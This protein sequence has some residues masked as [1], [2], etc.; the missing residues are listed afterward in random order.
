MT[1][2]FVRLGDLP[3]AR[4]LGPFKSRPEARFA[5]SLWTAQGHRCRLYSGPSKERCMDDFLYGTP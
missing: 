1:L 3:R 5:I 2:F 4:V